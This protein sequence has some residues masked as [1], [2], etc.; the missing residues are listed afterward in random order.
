MLTLQTHFTLTPKGVESIAGGS[1]E[2][3]MY[4]YVQKLFKHEINHIE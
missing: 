4:I 1:S 3:R 2:R